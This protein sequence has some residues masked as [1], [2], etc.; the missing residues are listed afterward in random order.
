[1]KRLLLLLLA[2]LISMNLAFAW[3]VC[4]QDKCGDDDATDGTAYLLPPY[5]LSTMYVSYDVCPGC[6]ID[7]TCEVGG[8]L[9][10]E[11]TWTGGGEEKIP[12]TLNGLEVRLKVYCHPNPD[13]PVKCPE[14]CIATVKLGNPEDFQCP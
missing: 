14:D 3:A 4:V 2:L 10:W 8:V 9:A 5:D 12:N 11:R 6:Q 13:G 1:M 7:V